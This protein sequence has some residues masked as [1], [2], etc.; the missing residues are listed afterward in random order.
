MNVSFAVQHHPARA[1][2]LAALL[3]RIG[4][5]VDAPGDP[6][7]DG[8]PNPWRCYRHTLQTTPPGATHRVVLQDDVEVCDGFRPAVEAAI[9]AQPARL[10]ALF[11]GGRP[12]EHALAL[13]RASDKG[14]SWAELRPDRWCPAVALCWPVEMIEPF[15]H[16][17]EMQRWPAGFRA[18]DEMIGRW[19]RTQGQGALATVP[20]LVEHPD[21]VPSLIGRRAWGGADVGRVA[22]CYIGDCDVTTIDWNLGP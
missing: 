19:L 3:T 16:Y 9:A 20:S 13:Y 4:G 6:E 18:D 7:P 10:L 8:Q 22:A 11:V 15:L 12:V 17:V 2:M 5:D 1:A 21:V 14:H